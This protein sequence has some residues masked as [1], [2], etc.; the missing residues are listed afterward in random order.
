MERGNYQSRAACG[1]QICSKRIFVQPFTITFSLKPRQTWKHPWLFSTTSSFWSRAGEAASPL[2]TEES[3]LLVK[4]KVGAR[5]VLEIR[6]ESQQSSSPQALPVGHQQAC[7]SY[8]FG[9]DAICES[10]GLEARSADA[11]RLCI[12]C[13]HHEPPWTPYITLSWTLAP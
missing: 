6:G 5:E 13:S 1:A 2:T 7:N 4:V 8:Q 12:A 9:G 11:H 10:K 3:C